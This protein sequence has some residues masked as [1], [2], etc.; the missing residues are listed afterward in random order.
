MSEIR[1]KKT[2]VKQKKT[3]TKRKRKEITR[4]IPVLDWAIS[5]K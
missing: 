4:N 3:K 1:K 2:D 5:T